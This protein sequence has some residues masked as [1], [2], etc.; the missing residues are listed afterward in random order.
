MQA[1]GS[2]GFFMMDPLLPEQLV[3][4]SRNRL[5]SVSAIK[6]FGQS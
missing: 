2:R 4:F 1:I 3:F 6:L 5:F